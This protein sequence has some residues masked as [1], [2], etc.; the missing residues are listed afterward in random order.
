[1]KL[2]CVGECPYCDVELITAA[3]PEGDSFGDIF[4]ASW[5][6]CRRFLETSDELLAAQDMLSNDTE[7]GIKVPAGITLGD[8]LF[9]RPGDVFPPPFVGV[10]PD[11]IGDWQA[12]GD[13]EAEISLL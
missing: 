3:F 10:L 1:M 13:G 9:R 12:L 5:K 8:I 2:V 4:E 6:V 7:M 11:D